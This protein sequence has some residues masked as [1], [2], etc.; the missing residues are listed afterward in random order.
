[1]FTVVR[2]FQRKE[3]VCYLSASLYTFASH[4][5]WMDFIPV[6]TVAKIMLGSHTDMPFNLIHLKVHKYLVMYL[7]PL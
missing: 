7:P 2:E 6:R 1:M 4:M 5:L 3:H